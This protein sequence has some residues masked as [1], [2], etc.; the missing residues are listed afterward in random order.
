ML[1]GNGA[2]LHLCGTGPIHRIHHDAGFVPE[3]IQGSIPG[4]DRPPPFPNSSGTHRNN[5]RYS[6]VDKAQQDI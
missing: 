4:P 6:A 2:F 1:C 3:G 5:A